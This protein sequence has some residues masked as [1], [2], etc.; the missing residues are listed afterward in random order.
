MHDN[1]NDKRYLVRENEQVYLD[2]Y[3]IG[4][5]KQGESIIILLYTLNEI[6]YSIVI[7]SYEENSNITDRILSKRLGQ[8]KINLLIWTHPHEDHSK[9]LIDILR[10]YSSE[11][12]II[13]TADVFD[14]SMEFDRYS[15]ENVKFIYN[16]YIYRKKMSS[17]RRIKSQVTCGDKLDC[18]KF[19]GGSVLEYMEIQCIAPISYISQYYRMQKQPDYNNIGIGCIVKIKI[20]NS[21]SDRRDINLL[22]GGDMNNLTLGA[23]KEDEEINIPENFN[24]IKIPHHGSWNSILLLDMLKENYERKIQ[25]ASTSI[26]EDKSTHLPNMRT[27]IFYKRYIEEIGCTFNRR[28]EIREPGI[29]KL[30]YN[31]SDGT[32]RKSEE[33]AAIWGI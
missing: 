20:K 28:N 5:S 27:L 6:I 19:I 30:T 32:V 33:G 18:V 23:L 3:H 12:T 4:Y 2:V 9:G 17:K 29:L 8:H 10:E 13:V 1:N 22:F 16:Q 7:D 14:P 24:Y 21:V 15:Q 31:L 11:K 25:Y 26:K